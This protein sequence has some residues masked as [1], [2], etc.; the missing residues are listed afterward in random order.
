MECDSRITP[1]VTIGL[2]ADVGHHGVR[3][4][5]PYRFLPALRLSIDG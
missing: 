2:D 5:L 4:I 3:Y 1:L